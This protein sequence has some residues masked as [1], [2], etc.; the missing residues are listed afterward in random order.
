MIKI[1]F[2]IDNIHGG[3][4]EKVL[5]TLVNHMDQSAFDITVQT[6][7]EADPAKYLAPG[8]RYKA[9]NRCKSAWGRKIF[10]YWVR[11]CA[12]VKLLYP[13]YIKDDYDIE[14]AYLECGPTK[15]LA[16]S[17]N[18]KAAKLAWVHCDLEKKEGIAGQIGRMKKFYGAY[19]QAVCVSQDVKR[20]F[21]R[22]FGN[23]AEARVLYNV[24]DEDEITEKA[25]AF[26]VPKARR[27]LVAVGRLAREKSFDRLLEACWRLKRDGYDFELQI[28]GEGPE[29]PAL[30]QIIREK[31]LGDC[32]ELL[33]FQENPYPYLKMADMVVCSSRYEGLSTVVIESL[34]LGKAIVTTPCTGMDELLGDSRYG[35]ITEDSA[36]GIYTGIKALLDAPQ[37]LADYE[38][39]AAQRGKDFSKETILA[40]TEEFF[41]SVLKRK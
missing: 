36:E 31:K 8:I 10:S 16:G 9:I 4:A 39:A 18:K 1:L 41:R 28:L 24:N 14:A 29:R 12:E 20:S 22:L 23:A 40:Q 2:L 27:R 21:E 5:R 15:M 17:T 6:V 38:K 32:V 35:L 19:D 7:E 3:G 37:R 11:L 33:G 34:I 13:L 25:A 26:V 30:E